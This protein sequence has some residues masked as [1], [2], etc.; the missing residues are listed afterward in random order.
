MYYLNQEFIMNI[1]AKLNNKFD[2]MCVYMLIY[3]C[4]LY[5]ELW[6]MELPTDTSLTVGL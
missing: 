3:V 1:H 5:V 6:E 2:T 4:M